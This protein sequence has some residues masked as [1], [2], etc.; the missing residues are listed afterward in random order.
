MYGYTPSDVVG[1]NL[2]ALVPPELQ[3]ELAHMLR[4]VAG[5]QSIRN[6]ETVRVRRDGSR[7]DVSITI[8]PIRDAGGDV[9]GA[10]TIARDITEHKRMVAELD[11][12]LAALETALGEARAAEERSRKF[13][14]DAAHHLRNPV[15]GIRSCVETILRGCPE[16][17]RERLVAEVI[18]DTSRI[19][20]LLDRLFRI[21]RLEQ[22]EALAMADGDLVDECRDAIE[23]AQSLAPG[24]VIEL[25]E[26]SAP[27]VAF[28]RDAVREILRSV[29]DNGCRHAK[30]R[31]DVEVHQSGAMA[32][33]RVGDDGPGLA[34]ADLDRAFEPFVSLDGSGSGLG[35]AISR[36]LAR[37]HG[38][39]LVY[40]EGAFVLRLPASSAIPR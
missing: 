40:E 10:S 33:V 5:G 30:R 8:S 17:D 36:A 39:D 22:G 3:D 25:A 38:G 23:R 4:V 6:H 34:E 15:A 16:P 29:L 9:V 28:D 11:A 27:D 32:Y 26:R 18:R 2:A 19:S 31:I 37:A 35:L 14:S 7:I 24:L 20:R 21:S 1:R 13:L 12:T